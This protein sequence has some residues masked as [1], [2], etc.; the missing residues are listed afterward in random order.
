MANINGATILQHTD[1]VPIVTFYVTAQTSRVNNS[2]VAVTFRIKGKLKYSAD[3]LLTGY[4]IKAYFTIAGVEKEVTVKG[5]SEQWRGKEWQEEKTLNFGNVT[6]T[7]PGDIN[8]SFRAKESAGSG[9]GDVNPTTYQLTMPPLLTTACTAPGSLTASPGLF[10]Q[11]ISLSWPAGSG[12]VN[13]PVTRYYIQYHISSDGVTWG[14]WTSDSGWHYP[15]ASTTG[16][17]LP[18]S[19]QAGITRGYYIQFRIRTEGS[20]GSSYYSGYTQSGSIRKNRLPAVPAS[21]TVSPSPFES[22]VTV[23]WGSAFDPDN[24][25]YRYELQYC[26]SSDGANWGIWFLLT[27]PLSTSYTYTPTLIDG[28][29]IKYHVR[30]VDSLGAVSY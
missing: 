22:S 3:Y 21:I 19:F 20:A 12:G 25:F 14:A 29:W 27:Y 13:N 11:Q 15:S 24:N 30:S 5:Y 6:S 7:V 1:D 23:A 26:T 16:I 10:E 28:A 8:I 18:A 17:A 2:T 4:T 9:C